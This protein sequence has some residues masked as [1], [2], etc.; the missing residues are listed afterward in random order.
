M[1]VLGI[2]WLGTK[3][4]AFDEMTH[5]AT[6]IMGMTPASRSDGLVVF[7]FPDGDEF[8]IFSAEHPGLPVDDQPVTAFLVEDVAAARAEM[9]AKGVA[10]IGEIEQAGNFAWTYFRAPDGKLY[11]LVHR[12]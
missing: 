10:F 6:E 2:A 7:H 11:E 9:E 4:S 12:V 3:T 1:R 8:E 5:F